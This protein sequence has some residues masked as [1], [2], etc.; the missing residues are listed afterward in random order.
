M[1]SRPLREIGAEQVCVFTEL[2]WYRNRETPQLL[3]DL[4]VFKSCLLKL[5]GDTLSTA[6]YTAL[7]LELPSHEEA[8]RSAF[9]YIRS[10]TKIATRLEA[11]L[12][13][14]I[15]PVV[16]PVAVKEP[17]GTDTGLRRTRRK[18]S[19][20]I[21]LSSLAMHHFPIFKRLDC[22]RTRLGT[23]VTVCPTLIARFLT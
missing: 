12:K 3:I 22:L 6:R 17:I 23:A 14:I 16:G 18:A 1:K 5:P 19:Y 9:S 2:R 11:L 7:L 10:L 4:G 13:V 15:T 21:T 20:S 8:D